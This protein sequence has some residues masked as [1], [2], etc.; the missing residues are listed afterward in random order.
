MK[1]QLVLGGVNCATSD[2]SGS[3]DAIGAATGAAMA[4]GA[5]A[6]GRPPASATASVAVARKRPLM[7]ANV[8]V[9]GPCSNVTARGDR[10]IGKGAKDRV[11]ARVRHA[12]TCHCDHKF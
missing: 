5:S 1:N 10:G 3:T 7:A 4:D 12:P 9:A 11:F 2:C 8:I 6:P